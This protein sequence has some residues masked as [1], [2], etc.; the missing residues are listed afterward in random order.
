MATHRKCFLTLVVGSNGT[1]KTTFLENNI[2]K[3]KSLI[4]TPDEIEYPNVRLIKN[5]SNLSKN[6]YE[7]SNTDIAK[8]IYEEN[9]EK[10]LR[11]FSNGTLVLD[12]CKT[13]LTSQT[14]ATMRELYIRRRQR[15]V[16][17]Y[18]VAHSLRQIPPSAFD[19]ANK[20]V[21]FKTM[22]NLKNRK[23][24]IDPFI[25][26]RIEKTKAELDKS[27]DPHIYKILVLLK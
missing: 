21:Y 15:M 10:I 3:G 27:P 14:P 2:I 6:I 12:D 24:L 18:F 7:M 11:N 17:V 20:L 23:D 4:V 8:V 26:Q 19:F 5:D 25:F 16:D 13:Y 22:E 9:L 1:G